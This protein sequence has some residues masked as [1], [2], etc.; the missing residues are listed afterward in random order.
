MKIFKKSNFN[1]EMV[2]KC[3][4]AMPLGEISDFRHGEFWGIC[5]ECHNNS[6]FIENTEQKKEIFPKNILEAE[7]LW[8]EGYDIYAMHEMSEEPVKITSLDQLRNYTPD[9]LM[10]K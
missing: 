2:S 7:R 10:A 8:S 4:G 9:Q 6:A 3:C 5:A 1:Q